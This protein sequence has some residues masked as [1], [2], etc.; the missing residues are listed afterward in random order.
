MNKADVRADLRLL[1][2]MAGTNVVLTVGVLVRL[3]SQ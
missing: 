1:K 3:L 2:W